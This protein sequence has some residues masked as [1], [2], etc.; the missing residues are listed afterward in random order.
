MKTSEAAKLLNVR[1]TT[2]LEYIK[3]GI[4]EAKQTQTG[5]WIVNDESV[6]R[7][8]QPQRKSV[9]YARVSTKKQKSHLDNQIEVCKQFMLNKGLSIDD[10]YSD[11]ASGMTLERKGLQKLIDDI[12]S[13]KIQSVIVAH[14]DRLTRIGFDTLAQL[15]K[16][17][18][19][20]VVI[21]DNS[22]RS[23]EKELL[24]EIVAILHTYASKL[25]GTRRKHLQNVAEHID[26]VK[27]EI[28]VCNDES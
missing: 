6:Y 12:T 19:C 1:T 9:I 16:K 14:K 15:F 10:V 7:L 28:N 3:K 22:K 11:I 2:V 18:G 20:E 13:Y 5:R 4:L 17:F 23:A 8:I 25:Y 21:V 27:E 24:E 26:I